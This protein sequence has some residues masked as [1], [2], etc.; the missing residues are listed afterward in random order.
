MMGYTGGMPTVL[1]VDGF[2]VRI[3]PRDHD[4]PHVHVFRAGGQAKVEIGDPDPEHPAPARLVQVAGMS[5]ADARQAEE[6]VQLHQAEL[7][8]AW[9]V[10][11][12]I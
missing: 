12:A 4:P 5:R 11:G 6:L 8:E 3:Y 2:E 10:Y 1:R 9:R 7:M